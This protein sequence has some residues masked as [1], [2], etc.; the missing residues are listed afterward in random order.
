M[1]LIGMGWLRRF[2]YMK[3][4]SQYWHTLGHQQHIIQTKASS[5]LVFGVDLGVFMS[6]LAFIQIDF[7]PRLERCKRDAGRVSAQHDQ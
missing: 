7:T 3:S 4:L 2:V 5:K 6:Q 1:V